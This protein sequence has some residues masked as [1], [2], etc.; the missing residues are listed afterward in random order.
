MQVCIIGGFILKLNHDQPKI[1]LEDS[2]ET[3]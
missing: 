2:I 3:K 1:T